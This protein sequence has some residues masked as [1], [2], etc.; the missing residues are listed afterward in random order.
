MCVALL[1]G[2]KEVHN[3]V[4]MAMELKLLLVE[5]A[6]H[7]WTRW[8]DIDRQCKWTDGYLVLM[9]KIMVHLKRAKEE[10]PEVEYVR[11]TR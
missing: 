8:M 4:V 2:S 1:D 9:D 11:I 6:Q 5:M 3:H 7:L 10:A